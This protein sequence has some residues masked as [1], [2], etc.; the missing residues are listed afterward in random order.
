MLLTLSFALSS[1]FFH[2]YLPLLPTLHRISFYLLLKVPLTILIQKLIAL[3]LFAGLALPQVLPES[4]LWGVGA[5]LLSVLSVPPL[6][7]NAG[8][9][10]PLPLHMLQLSLPRAA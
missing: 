5:L 10:L 2:S 4:S 8:I 9:R 6:Q 1:L 3:K 7:N